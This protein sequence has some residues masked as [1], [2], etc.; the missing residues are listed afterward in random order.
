MR[1]LSFSNKKKLQQKDS[2]SERGAVGATS[3]FFPVQ[4]AVTHLANS[5]GKTKFE[6]EFFVL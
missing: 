4:K 6:L 3:T 1:F 2:N 5:P